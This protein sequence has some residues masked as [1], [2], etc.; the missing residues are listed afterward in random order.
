MTSGTGARDY[1]D[2]NIGEWGKL[3]RQRSHPDETLEAPA[4][5]RAIYRRT[6]VPIEARLM[7]RRFAITMEFIARHVQ[8]GMHVVDVGCGTGIFTV[9]LLRRGAAVTAVD[10]APRALE[11]TR[12][13]VEQTL[14]ARAKAARYRLMDVTQQRLPESDLV[15][16]LGVTPY[17]EDLD[18]FYANILPT[19][20]LFYCLVLDPQH[21]AN[22]V[23]RLVPTLNVRHVHWF[24]RA[25]VDALLRAA[26]WRLIERQSFAS[27]YLDTAARAGRDDA[28][29]TRQR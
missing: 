27:G 21:W 17:V 28:E 2:R 5:L 26:R 3:Y 18:A 4:W 9:E 20:Q 7:A 29:P 10:C 23:R 12:A 22:R 14:P 19:T 1:W 8:E 16:A 24:E 6:I 13:L 25:R 11:L 15:L